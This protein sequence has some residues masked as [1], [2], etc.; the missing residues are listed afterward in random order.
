[1]GEA[2]E[3][4]LV[5]VLETEDVEEIPLEIEI[6][7]WELLVE[8]RELLVELREL[9]VGLKEVLEELERA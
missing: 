8:L 7:L 1:V 3:D 2:V 6:E 4:V 5:L 9:L